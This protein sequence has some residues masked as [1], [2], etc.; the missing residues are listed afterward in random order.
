MATVTVRVPVTEIPRLPFPHPGAASRNSRRRGSTP[1]RQRD[2]EATIWRNPLHVSS[3]SGRTTRSTSHYR[4]HRQRAKVDGD[5]DLLG[6]ASRSE[7]SPMQSATHSTR[8]CT[9]AET[10]ASAGRVARDGHAFSWWMVGTDA[11]RSASS[12]PSARRISSRMNSSEYRS[13][14]HSTRSCQKA[15]T[16]SDGR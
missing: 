1:C 15:H 6:R 16:D 11:H 2:V 8:N 10:W 7:R 12:Y 3:S 9:S 5:L 14:L 4:D 13:G